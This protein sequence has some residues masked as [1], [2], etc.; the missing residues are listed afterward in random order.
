[1]LRLEH[2]GQYRT[3]QLDRIVGIIRDSYAVNIIRKLNSTSRIVLVL[4]A[5]C[6]FLLVLFQCYSSYF[7]YTVTFDDGTISTLLSVS[8][9]VCRCCLEEWRSGGE[10]SKNQQIISNNLIILF[11][12]VQLD[13]AK[14]AARR[15]PFQ[16]LLSHIIINDTKLNISR[17]RNILYTKCR[18]SFILNLYNFRSIKLS[19]TF[20]SILQ[21]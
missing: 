18:K 7:L 1:M 10:H 3:P 11:W 17:N 9:S 5:A 16:T 2:R 13:W 15:H 12:E 14:P 20:A 19:E 6:S 21:K 4:S 8:V